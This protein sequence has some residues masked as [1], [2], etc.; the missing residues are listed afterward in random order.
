MSELQAKA[1]ALESLI[2][3]RKSGRFSCLIAKKIDAAILN[4]SDQ[5]VGYKLEIEITGQVECLT[6]KT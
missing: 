5:I 4:M 6:T 1:D 2:K 3:W